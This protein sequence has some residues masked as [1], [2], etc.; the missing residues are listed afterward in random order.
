MPPPRIPI[1]IL[2]IGS[3]YQDLL[4]KSPSK[5]EDIK[6]EDIKGETSNGEDIKHKQRR[7]HQTKWRGQNDLEVVT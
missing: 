7:G 1:L 3:R 6:G 2:S 4:G 5:G